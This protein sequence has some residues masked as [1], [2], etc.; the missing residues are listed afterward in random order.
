MKNKHVSSKIYTEEYYLN[1]CLGFEEFRKYKGRRVNNRIRDFV[2]ML[3]VKKGDRVIDMGC[4]RGDLT[5]EL[6]R[7]G[8]TAVGI[9][10]SSD[11]IKLAKN[12]LKYQPV[13]IQNNVKFYEMNAKKLE[14]KNNSFDSII[15]VDVFEH[16]YKP[17]LEIA[18][19][20]ISRV[21]K[22][23][24]TLLIH[25]ETN[26]IY[27]DFTHRIWCYPLDYLLLQMNKALFKS[28]YPG[29]PKD[30][31]NDI[32]KAQHVN[33]PTFFYLR[34]L[35]GRHNFKGQIFPFVPYKPLISWKDLAYN[36]PVYLYPVSS[37]FPFHLLFT[38]EFICKM[39][40]VKN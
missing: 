1:S 11:G 31:R 9:D 26:K 35:F 3:D 30:P 25:T 34:G 4:G 14:F 20:E 8:A 29:L 32:H 19:K 40:N 5:M 17:E 6:A 22:P 33:E 39:R 2:S 7:Q 23:G 27:L 24:G 15:S 16:L 12:A 38:T 36:I 18:M 37:L 21:L 28:E 13:N 10:Y